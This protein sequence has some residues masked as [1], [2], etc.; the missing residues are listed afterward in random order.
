MGIFT[1]TAAGTAPLSYQWQVSADNGSNWNNLA[2][3]GAYNGV[4]LAT[5]TVS[6]SSGLTGYQYRCL[7]SNSA[8]TATSNAATLTVNPATVAPSITAQPSNQTVTAGQN[9]T[10]TLAASGTPAPTF[11]W[12]LSTDNGSNWNELPHQGAYNG[13]DLAKPTVS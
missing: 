13:G 8:G 5:L 6:T 11:Q 2:N 10:F 7:V 3:A 4:N 9:A 1:V 12:Q